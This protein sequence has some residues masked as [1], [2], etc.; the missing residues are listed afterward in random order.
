MAGAGRPPELA[1]LVR[2][3]ASVLRD[4]H[5][6]GREVEDCYGDL[7]RGAPPGTLSKVGIAARSA[8]HPGPGASLQELDR[9]VQV[10]D[11]LARFLGALVPTIPPGLRVET[12]AAEGELLLRDLAAR[13]LRPADSGLCGQALPAPAARSGPGPHA[14]EAEDGLHLF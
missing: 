9:L 3:L 2:R 1:D 14:A 4:A 13:L 8:G 6:A 11:N 5:A 12:A 7:I 10:L